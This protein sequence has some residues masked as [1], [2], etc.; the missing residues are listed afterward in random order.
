MLVLSIAVLLIVAYSA[1]QLRALVNAQAAILAFLEKSIDDLTKKVT[2]VSGKI[3]PEP[4]AHGWFDEGWTVRKTEWEDNAPLDNPPPGRGGMDVL[5]YQMW[6]A[7]FKEIGDPL[8][9]VKFLRSLKRT[10]VWITKEFRDVIY[11][12]RS[13]YVRAWAAGHLRSDDHEEV[14]ISDSEPN[15]RAALWSNPDCRRLPW[16]SIWVNENWKVEFQKMSSLDRL[17][18]MRNPDLSKYYVLALL[19]TPTQELQITR[20][21][22]ASVAI[23]AAVNQDLIGSSR[24]HGRRNFKGFDWSPPFEEFGQMWETC[25]T[26]WMDQPSVP[27]FFFRYIQTVPEKK[28]AVYR[29][30]LERTEDDVLA[31][32]EA[33]VKSCDRILD[34]ELLKAAW[35][36]PHRHCRR[37]AKERIGE[38]AE[39]VGVKCRTDDD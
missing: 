7:E 19:Q 11:A 14:L 24:W 15:V 27:F 37:F 13:V 31:C 4:V 10:G 23:A 36:D 32:R 30:L 38:H 21:E 16:N 6:I 3:D 17:G 2:E 18:L 29:A 33:I 20:E 8:A 25:L 34:R 5:A 39:F 35:D 28:L 12:D 26:H 22:H 9:R 1:S